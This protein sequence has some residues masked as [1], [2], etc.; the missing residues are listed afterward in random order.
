MLAVDV[1]GSET[2]NINMNEVAKQ[3]IE[4]DKEPI[5][6]LENLT[7][8]QVLQRFAESNQ[9]YLMR[10]FSEEFL[11]NFYHHLFRLLTID[12]LIKINKSTHTVEMVVS[13]K[14]NNGKY[15]PKT[16]EKLEYCYVLEWDYEREKE[17]PPKLGEKVVK[18]EL[19]TPSKHNL[20]IKIN[21]SFPLRGYLP[22]LCEFD[23]NQQFTAIERLVK[24]IH[25]IFVFKMKQTGEM[26]RIEFLVNRLIKEMNLELTDWGE[27]RKFANIIDISIDG[28]DFSAKIE[29]QIF[30]AALPELGVEK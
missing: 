18:V 4:I 6:S 21:N 13:Y 1:F 17:I 7:D 23:Y 25:T 2:M 22:E 28:V 12:C 10:E 19:T 29:K 24:D 26:P 3:L 30:Q 9:Y 20:L 16:V 27:V 5:T 8:E 15:T 11:P 14:K